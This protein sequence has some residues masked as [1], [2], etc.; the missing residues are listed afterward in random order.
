M[1]LRWPDEELLD[2]YVAALRRGW[3]PDTV[4]AAVAFEQLAA[5]EADPGG[6]LASLVDRDASGPPIPLPDGSFG[7]RL[8]GFHKWMWDGEFCGSIGLRWAPGTAELPPRV[9]GHIGYSVVP[10]KRRL[11]HATSALGQM[12]DE[13]VQEGLPYVI[14][15]TDLDNVASQR[16]IEA[17][18]GALL[19]S[20]TKDQAY[21]GTCGLRYR[22]DLARP[23]FT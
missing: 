16:V 17:N 22:I 19:G 12:L 13:A 9:L 3:S 5:I 8:P 21:G 23:S 4:R 10:W 14:L 7:T 20:F 2:S 18:G 15:T 1:E 6:F 11:G